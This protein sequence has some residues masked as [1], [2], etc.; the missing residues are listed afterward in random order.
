MALCASNLLLLA[1]VL[2]IIL[3]D[4]YTHKSN[5][6]IEHAILGGILCFLFYLM[7]IY[8][9]EKINW[10]FLALIPLYIFI[11]WVYTPPSEDNDCSEDDECN[12]CQ[13]P[14]SFN[15]IQKENAK[16][17]ARIKCLKTLN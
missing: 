17:K 15:D 7:C 1:L 13:K 12:V 14:K 4:I 16:A 2:L 5:F 9:Y 11:K 6:I 3:N 8:G 10:V